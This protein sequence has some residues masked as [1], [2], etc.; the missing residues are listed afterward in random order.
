MKS[1]LTALA[2]STILVLF[3]LPASA[4]PLDRLDIA[5]GIFA[6]QGAQYGWRRLDPPGG[7]AGYRCYKVCS[8]WAPGVPGTFA[9]RCVGWKMN[10]GIFSPSTPVR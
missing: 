4:V 8:R 1:L 6:P 10:C 9:G 2:L 3:A 5:S 7:T